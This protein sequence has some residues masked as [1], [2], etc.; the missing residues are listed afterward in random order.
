MRGYG[1]DTC[2]FVSC[3]FGQYCINGIC[4]VSSSLGGYG[5]LGSNLGGSYGASLGGY[6]SSLNGLGGLGYGG[7]FG[8]ANKC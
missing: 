7:I 2:R 8:E 6:G 1:T 3:P 5:S 4:S